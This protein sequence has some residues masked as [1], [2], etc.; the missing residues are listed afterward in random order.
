MSKSGG[1]QRT[2]R[3]GKSLTMNYA[4]LS[5]QRTGDDNCVSFVCNTSFWPSFITVLLKS[6]LYR[7]SLGKPNALLLF[8]RICCNIFFSFSACCGSCNRCCCICLSRVPVASLTASFVLGLGF[9]GFAL[10]LSE[11][12]NNLNKWLKMDIV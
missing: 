9:T 6:P 10:G 4:S 2:E 11:G 3:N 8:S 7:L 1:L 12:I 5:S